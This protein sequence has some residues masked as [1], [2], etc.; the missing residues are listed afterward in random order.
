MDNEISRIALN[1]PMVLR[2]WL[3]KKSKENHRSLTAEIVA[4]VRENKEKDEARR[5]K[6]V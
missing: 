6:A 3:N 1:M 2:V 5:G 4:M